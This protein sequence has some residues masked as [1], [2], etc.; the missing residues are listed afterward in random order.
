MAA[1]QNALGRLLQVRET[2]TTETYDRATRQQNAFAFANVQS[3][4]TSYCPY[5]PTERTAAPRPRPIV[6]TLKCSMSMAGR[7]GWE[8]SR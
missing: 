7:R 3:D 8:Q 6:T 2:E 5:S 4:T 1:R